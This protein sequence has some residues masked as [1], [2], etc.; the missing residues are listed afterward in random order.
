MN[1]D[2][3]LNKFTVPGFTGL[4]PEFGTKKPNGESVSS[5]EAHANIAMALSLMRPHVVNESSTTT[6]LEANHVFDITV[7]NVTLEI[8]EAAFNGCKVHIVNSSGGDVSVLRNGTEN[9]IIHSGEIIDMEFNGKWSSKKPKDMLRS[10]SAFSLSENNPTVASTEN[11]DT[12]TGGF[13]TIDGVLLQSGDRVLLKDQNNP[14]E[15]GIWVPQTGKWNRDSVYP[16]GDSSIL[17][18]KFI[19]PLHGETQKGKMYYLLEDDYIIE[20]SP[21][22]FAESLFAYS[23]ISGKVIMRDPSGRAEVAAPTEKNHIARKQETDTVQENLDKTQL[24]N[25]ARPGRNLLEVFGVS[26]IQDVMAI[27]RQRC[28]GEGIPDFTGIQIGDYLDIPSLTVSGTVYTQNLRILVSGFNTFRNPLNTSGAQNIKNHI[29]FTF[30]SIVLKKRMNATNNN[31][32]GY[33]ASELRV[34]LEGA[35]GDG[36]GPFAVGLKNAIGDYLYTV[37]RYASRKGAMAWNNYTVF[38]PTEKE[39]GVPYYVSDTIYS[40]DE[41]DD[42]D[43]QIRWP[44]FQVRA[45]QKQYNGAWGSWWWIASPCQ[46]VSTNF[47]IVSRTGLIRDTSASDTDG[48]VAPAFCIA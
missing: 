3:T 23:G 45:A 37:R 31:A 34:F 11:V 21:L 5:R 43:L 2:C 4:D 35:E 47:C 25:L 17:T 27:L 8:S 9:L 24:N 44:I 10:L 18:N 15:N 26:T 22:H 30:D 36:S 28:N 1:I 7:A 39:V 19:S 13:L 16:A 20:I 46:N 32:G 41:K 33:P 29:L 12:E 6:E 40:G 38:L 48:G 42:Y 14:V